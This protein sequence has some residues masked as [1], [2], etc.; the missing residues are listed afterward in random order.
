MKD[1][2]Y[3]DL[4][5]IMALA[6]EKHVD[7]NALFLQTLKNYETVQSAI[8][9][10]DE[11]MQGETVLVSKEYVKGRENVYLHP[12]IKELSKLVDASNKTLDKLLLII[13]KE[14]ETDEGN[15]LLE[16]VNSH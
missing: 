6:K 10:I 5:S 4:K 16:W 2:P 14:N 13:E 3:F 15:E 1:K 11:E 8:G 9:K 12:G 7:E